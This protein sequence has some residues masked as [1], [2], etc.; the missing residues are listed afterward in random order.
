[1]TRGRGYELRLPDGE[2]DATRFERLLRASRARARRSRCGAATRSP[3]SRA[4]RS[5][6]P[7]SAGSTSCGCAR[8]SCAIEADLAGGPARARCSAS[9]S[10]WSTQQPLRERLHAQR[11]L[12][13]Y[14]SGRQAEALEAYRD[15]RSRC[16]SS[17]SASSPGAELRRLQ[18]AILA[19]DPA[20]DA[21]PPP[22]RRRA[23]APARSRRRAPRAARRGRPG[24]SLAR[25]RVRRDPRD[26]SPR[27]CRGIDENYVGADRRGE[28]SD[29]RAVPGRQ[30]PERGRRSAAARSGS[31]TGR[32]DRLADRPRARQPVDDH[33]SA[34][35]PSALAFGARIAVGRRRRRAQGAA[36][37]PEREPGRAADRGRQRAA[38]ARR[39][40]RARCGSPRGSTGASARID[41]R[42]R[43]RGASRSTSARTRARSPRAPAR[44]GWRA[45][46]PA[47]VTR[48]EPRTGSV[49]RHDRRRQRAE[50]DRG[51]RGRRV[52]RQPPRRN[53]DADRPGDER[54]AGTRARRPRSD[55]GR[56]RRRRGLGRRRRATARSPASIPDGPRDVERLTP[57]AARRRSPSP[58]GRCGPRRL[59]PPAAT[60]AARCAA[61]CRRDRG[62]AA[63]RLAASSPTTSWHVQ[64][65]SLAYDGLV[66]YRRVEGAA[67]AT[68]VGALATDVPAPSPDGRTY[69]FTLRPRAPLL[70]RRARPARGLP[71]LD[72]ALAARHP[73]RR[74]R[75]FRGHRRGSGVRAAGRRAATCPRGIETDARARTITIHLTRPTRIS[76]T[77]SPA[78]GLRRAR[79]TAPSRARRVGR[80]PAPGPTGS[81]LGHASR[82]GRSSAT[83]TS[84]RA[85][86]ARPAGFADRIEVESA[87]E[88]TS[89]PQIADVQRGAADVAVVANPFASFVDGERLRA[90]AARSPGGS[91]ARPAPT[92][93]WMFLNVRRRPF[94][95]VRVRRAVNFAIDRRA[96]SSWRAAPSS[97]SRPARSCRPR[98]P[99]YAPYCPLHRG[100]GGGGGWTAPDM[101]RARR[102][103]A[104]VRAGGRARRRARAG[105]SD[106]RSA[107]ISR[108]C[109]TSSASARRCASSEPADYS[110]STSPAPGRRRARRMGRRLPQRPRASSRPNFTCAPGDPTRTNVSRL[111]DAALERR[112]DRALAAPPADAGRAG[113]PPTGASATS[114]RRCR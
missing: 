67:G 91:T 110:D 38:A 49:V 45:R 99:G 5:P 83:R 60:A 93:D 90:L 29:H 30:G 89:E 84:G 25:R 95:D 24:R 109:S 87:R 57:A 22:R 101:E 40:R 47:P 51:G 6:P 39:R 11:M 56:R 26:S 8:P 105:L 61:R 68:L 104:A 52:G 36:G 79:R 81:P 113:P 16:S 102:L 112:I 80:R 37:R 106:A 114:R 71:R 23:A 50:R 19:Q 42:T 46:R 1:M 44:C 77:S 75:R 97:A 59:A 18:D 32:R 82:G 103:V 31:R 20:L 15:A 43:P 17:R 96:S 98:S 28:R 33:R 76:C 88:P 53:A 66:A 9:S 27:G 2:V 62:L 63:D 55:R 3:T 48:I 12:A 21:S 58:A 13:L 100:P 94:D 65:S 70:G 111:C 41:A 7:R 107:G 78:V 14:R 72:G 73:P 85:G 54:V 69:V 92:T 4:S 34:A 108:G 10:G 64:L 86:A 74:S 35:S